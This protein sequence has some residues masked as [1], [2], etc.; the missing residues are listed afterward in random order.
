MAHIENNTP[1]KMQNPVPQN[2]LLFEF[3]MNALRLKAS[4]KLT[5]LQQRT[6]LSKNLAVNALQHGI[7]QKWVEVAD[8]WIRCTEP[9]YLFIDEILQS[10]LPEQ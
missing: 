1:Y 6:G 7:N 9:G 4:I 10:L 5:T 2:Q 8:D 3:M